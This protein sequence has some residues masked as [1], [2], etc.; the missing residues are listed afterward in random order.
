VLFVLAALYTLFLFYLFITAF[1][2]LRNVA[3]FGESYIILHL[4]NLPMLSVSC[5]IF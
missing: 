5:F 1:I 2:E 4:N 3:Y